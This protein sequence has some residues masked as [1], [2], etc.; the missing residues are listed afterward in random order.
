[1]VLIT[2]FIRTSLDRL[3]VKE[4]TLPPQPGAQQTQIQIQQLPAEKRTEEER[5][6]KISSIIRTLGVI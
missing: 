4:A 1:M 3:N 5:I 2:F 6:K